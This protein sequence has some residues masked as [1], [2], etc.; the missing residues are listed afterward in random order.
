MFSLEEGGW[1]RDIWDVS[2]VK[3]E[4][5]RGVWFKA[6]RGYALDSLVLDIQLSESCDKIPIN[7]DRNFA[8]RYDKQVHNLNIWCLN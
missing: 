4:V 7:I 3:R 6:T 8:I 1:F 2:A 5:R